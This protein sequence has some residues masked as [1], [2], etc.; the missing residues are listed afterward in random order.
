MCHDTNTYTKSMVLILGLN[1]RYVNVP[2]GACQEKYP[3]L[4]ERETENGADKPEQMRTQTQTYIIVTTTQRRTNKSKVRR[5]T[6]GKIECMSKN[7][8]IMVVSVCVSVHRCDVH[9]QQA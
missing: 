5:D 6:G 8:A 2:I 7:R 9:L 1:D 4:S 3:F